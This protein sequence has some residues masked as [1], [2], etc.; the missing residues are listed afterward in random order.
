MCSSSTLYLYVRMCLCVKV[1]VFLP[2]YMRVILA[3]LNKFDLAYF[4]LYIEKNELMQVFVG[5]A[6]VF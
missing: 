2:E 6:M 5:Q 4:S 3:E 1:F